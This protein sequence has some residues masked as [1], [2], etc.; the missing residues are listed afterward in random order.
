MSDNKMYVNFFKQNYMNV[1]SVWYSN[2]G[3]QHG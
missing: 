3:T 2:A 1:N